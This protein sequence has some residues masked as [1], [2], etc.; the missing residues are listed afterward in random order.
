MADELLVAGV[1]R[2]M[3][4]QVLPGDEAAIERAVDAAVRAHLDGASTTEA[5]GWGRV[6]MESQ[7][8][9]PACHH[10]RPLASVS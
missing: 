4:A 10:H 2:A 3:G 1:V 5:C 9:H 8:R 7:A 6:L